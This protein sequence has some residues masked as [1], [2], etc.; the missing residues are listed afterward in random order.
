VYHDRDLYSDALTYYRRSIEVKQKLDNKRGIAVSTTNIGK[1]YLEMGDYDEAIR[2]Y[3]DCMEMYD[4]TFTDRRVLTYTLCG[5]AETYLRRHELKNAMTYCKRGYVEAKKI[6][7]K[8][9]IGWSNRILGMIYSEKQNWQRAEKHFNKSIEVLSEMGS[10]TEL[11]LTQF[12][13]G[14]FWKKMGDFK[15]ARKH[16]RSALRIFRAKMIMKKIDLVKREL[17]G[18]S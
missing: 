7:V 16:L 6:G 3:L 17:D 14:K 12:E 1:T 15:N 2:R 13:F 5:L 9:N 10:E 18:L 11:G 4:E 8:E